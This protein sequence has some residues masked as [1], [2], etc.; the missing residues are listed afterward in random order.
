M[1]KGLFIYPWDIIDIGLENIAP[2]LQQL[3]ITSV[4]LAVSYH[5]AKVLLPHN[6][7]RRIFVHKSGRSYYPFDSN[8]YGCLKPEAGEFLSEYDGV[9]LRDAVEEFHKKQIETDAWTVVFHNSRLAGNHPECAIRNAY[10][11]TSPSSLCPSNDE[12]YRYGLQMLYDIAAAGVDR[13]NTESVDFAGLLH[14]D[15]HEMYAYE[16]TASMER[17]L[18]VCF[19]ESCMKRA[20]E[21]G[22]DARKVQKKVIEMTERFLKL[23]TIDSDDIEKQLENYQSVQRDRITG[24]YADL[25]NRLNQNKLKTHIVPIVWLA[26]G[27]N[28]R[29][30]GM[31]VERVAQITDGLIAAYPGSPEQVAEFVLNVRR[32]APG[33]RE[34][35][36][37]IRLMAPQT[38]KPQ[39]VK[40]Y[41]KEYR[42]NGIEKVLFYNYGLAPLPFLDEIREDACNE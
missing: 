26:G 30:Y 32:M 1:R 15:H 19:C 40:Q 17:L 27:S 38:V 3:Q 9:F 21:A 14:G 28:P 31:D 39:Q 2:E 34:I 22:V 35:V 18:G 29:Q 23:E 16:N 20:A 13:I 25:K 36:G 11:E 5:Q 37:G 12:V 8:D 7:N 42:K 41:M 33:S 4:S 24:F 10:G 6:P